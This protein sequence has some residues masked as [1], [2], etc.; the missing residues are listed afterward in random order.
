MLQSADKQSLIFAFQKQTL[1]LA[2]TDKDV[3]FDVN[4]P[5][6]KVKAK[7]ELKDMLYQGTLAL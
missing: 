1:P 4:L 6:L 3:T 2:E 5:S 7:F